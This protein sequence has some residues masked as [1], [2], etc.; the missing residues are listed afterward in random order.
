MIIGW[1][2]ELFNSV[3]EDFKEVNN[4]LNKE[5]CPVEPKLDP[6]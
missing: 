5:I 3:V 4:L 2:K 1:E 6:A